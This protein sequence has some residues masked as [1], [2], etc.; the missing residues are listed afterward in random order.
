MD[1][2]TELRHH[3]YSIGWICALS[4]EAA[5]AKAMLDEKQPPLYQDMNDRPHNVVITCL[6]AGVTGTNAAATVATQMFR[7]FTQIRICLMVGI[8]GGVPG[9]DRDVRLGDVVVGQD[10]VVQYDLG[11]TIQGGAFQQ[12]GVLT[13]PPASLLSI[14]SEL[15]TK[16]MMDGSHF[17]N[18]IPDA[19]KSFPNMAVDF[20]F[21]GAG[22][23]VLFKSG[24]DHPQGLPNCSNCDPHHIEDRAMRTPQLP[25]VHY[26]L[27]ASGNQVMR[28]GAT[29][30]KLRAETKAICF[31]MEAAG[32]VDIV[33]SL[34]IRGI[35]D[36]SD[37]HKNKAWQP[38]AALTAACYAR[39]YL[40]EAPTARVNQVQSITGTASVLDSIAS[41]TRTNSQILSAPI[42][43]IPSQFNASDDLLVKD[44]KL[45]ELARAAEKSLKDA[46]TRLRSA[47]AHNQ[48]ATFKPCSP[49]DVRFV[50]FKIQK[51]QASA[52]CCMD[53]TRMNKLLDGVQTFAKE[54]RF[55]EKSELIPFLC[56]MIHLSLQRTANTPVAFDLLLKTYKT[57][58][59]SITYDEEAVSWISQIPNNKDLLMARIGE[60]I[61]KL[62]CL[63]LQTLEIPD[64]LMGKA[65]ASTWHSLSPQREQLHQDLRG[66]K[67]LVESRANVITVV[68]H[69]QRRALLLE[70]GGS[71]LIDSKE[72]WSKLQQWLAGADCIQNHADVRQIRES[73]P[74]SGHWL[75]QHQRY[76]SW[77]RDDIPQTPILWL[78][79][80]LGAG[81]TVLASGI[82]DDCNLD[83]KSRTAFFYCYHDDPQRK[84]SLPIL[85]SILA[86]LTTSD[87]IL[88]PWCYEQYTTSNQL[89][90]RDEAQCI[91]MLRSILLSNKKTFVVLDGI[92]EC[93]RKDRQLL[94]SFFTRAVAACESNDPGSL[95]I[96][97]LSRDEDDI[98]RALAGAI[99][100]IKITPAENERDMK[101]Y[102]KL[103][104]NEVKD[105]FE[106]LRAD[107]IK[108][109]SDST[110]LRA[111]GMFLFAKL[112]LTNLLEQVSLEALQSE[113]EP[114]N[115]PA[116]LDAAYGRIIHRIKNDFDPNN[117]GHARKILGWVTCSVRPLKWHEIQGA[118]SVNTTDRDINFAGRRSRVHV[119]EIC[120]SLISNLSGDRV[121]L[122]HMSA[123]DYLIRSTFVDFASAQINLASLCLD[124]LSFDC[125]ESGHE[126]EQVKQSSLKGCF[127]FQDYAAAHWPDHTTA[128]IN[129]GS[130]ALSG[131]GQAGDMFKSALLD[132]LTH[133]EL[134]PVE[135]S[136]D[137][138][139]DLSCL[140]FRD[141]SYAAN[142]SHIVGMIRQQKAK[143]N[144]GL[145]EI[146]PN[147]LERVVLA[148]RAQ[149]EQLTLA[150]V[151]T[152]GNLE[153]FYGRKWYKC[154]KAACYYFH[155][156]FL[157]E[158]ERNYHV[159]RHE[160]P[161][162]CTDVTC[163]TGYRVG[164]TTAKLLEKHL[165]VH[166]PESKQITAIFTRL[167][168]ERSSG[169][170]LPK[171]GTNISTN[172]G[173]FSC[174][175]CLRTYT[176]KE[177]LNNHLRTHREDQTLYKC[178]VAECEKS[179]F[180]DDERKRHEREVHS[181]EKRFSCTVELKYGIPGSKSCGCNKGFPRLASLVSHW[182]SKN[183]QACLKPLRDEEELE[184]Q[185]ENQ[186]VRRKADGLELPLPRQLYEQFPDLRKSNFALPAVGTIG[187]GQQ[188]AG[189]EKWQP[190]KSNTTPEAAISEAEMHTS[191]RTEGAAAPRMFAEPS[192]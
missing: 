8:G 178:S 73:T 46:F 9:G 118:L 97:L 103:R 17:S 16:Y 82:I 137:Q 52:S 143:G 1:A 140:P 50:L 77:R 2:S 114:S 148:N 19:F 94:L 86:Q 141:E 64:P 22:D 132:F 164:F 173:K 78:S 56:G 115:F 128:V 27:I 145:D 121:E 72:Q 88:M 10:G 62:Q 126:A 134:E 43:A 167:K 104:C 15:K 87:H 123:K 51:Q 146:I 176:R 45:Q 172:T 26:G 41:I 74:K 180:R 102:I 142:T 144:K 55:E 138:G 59:N 91:D 20:A 28:H 113:I 191:D 7:T 61:L 85:A 158:K 38:Y 69:E 175:I 25:K 106:E 35:C 37:S 174:H 187:D 151:E 192:E 166:H 65:F 99:S 129:A 48:H 67:G 147:E 34:V 83:D 109:I 75:S 68:D 100:E 136:A 120:G 32:L 110:F 47:L 154:P 168:K 165:T 133:Y 117:I 13:K 60:N 185:W 162:R 101:R 139:L 71:A 130:S 4:V 36:Y 30:E 31:E 160:Y 53:L 122:V 93:E 95:R 107:A 188:Q 182:R 84:K 157:T 170:H 96:A 5:A 21:P 33:P 98:R 81:K 124:Y 179:F 189:L 156:G 54:L 111:D 159:M 92:D 108:Y 39:A 184:R 14:L 12:T 3:D 149:I 79:G 44:Q 163:E 190:F 66:Y 76:V 29:R 135:D 105:K 171:Q 161:F 119:R 90:L 183:G 18:Y 155:E 57:I 131:H 112:V 49:R 181:E 70:R 150:D 40:L 125:F 127:A 80:A 6:P 11:K 169:A 116:G 58:G 23:D 177:K 42:F 24:Y 186:I 152:R 89:S 63:I 153:D